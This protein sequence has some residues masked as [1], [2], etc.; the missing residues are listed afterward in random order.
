MAFRIVCVMKSDVV[1]VENPADRV[2]THT[3]MEEG[4]AA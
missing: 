4:L 1:A 3:V 2:M